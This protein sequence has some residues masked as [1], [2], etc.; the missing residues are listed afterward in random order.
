[1]TTASKDR[2]QIN[3]ATIGEGTIIIRSDPNPGLEGLNRDLARA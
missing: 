1:M 2:R 3:R